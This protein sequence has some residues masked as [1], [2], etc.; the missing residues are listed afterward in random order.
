M[1]T[2][3]ISVPA[4][5]VLALSFLMAVGSVTFLAP[6]VHEDGSFGSCHWAGRMCLGIGCVLFVL[7]LFTLVHKSHEKKA[8]LYQAMVPVSLLG[9][10]TPG[11]L[12]SLC[13]MSTMRC[14]A[15][16]QPAVILLSALILA[17]SLIGWLTERRKR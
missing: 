17:V 10:L 7:G 4:C 13:K 6:C 5:I 2:K 3:N 1:K 9:I 11:V 15:V 16:M 12:I 8:A 14:R